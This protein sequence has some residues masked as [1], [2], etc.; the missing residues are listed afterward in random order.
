MMK[1]MLV[2]ALCLLL[3]C[4]MF[5]GCTKKETTGLQRIKDKGTLILATESTYP[6]FQYLIIEDGKTINAGLDV[7]I[8]RNFAESIGVELV[9]H[10]MAF[11]SIIPAVQAGTV[12][13]GGSFTPTPE[14]AEVVDFSD[15]YYYSN[16]NVIVRV[17]EGEQFT[18]EESLQGKRIGAQKGTVQEQILA[19]MEGV[20]VLALPK[21]TSLIQELINGNIDGIMADFSVADTYVAAYPENVE[22]A[23][24][25]IPDE[26][27]GVA[28][29]QAKGQEDLM[30][31]LN[32][33]IKAGI[34][35]G[36]IEA[37]YDENLNA[38][39]DQILEAME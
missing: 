22:K 32:D 28:M 14:R 36:S 17:G 30:K 26:S 25:E 15:I 38:A 31:A 10:E 16:H 8:M 21:V 6:P 1:K 23:P 35:D 18:G 13:F 39:I 9:V 37:L 19:D 29:C 4:S 7:D 5:V 20:D 27:G 2:M 11:D 3:V 12:D 24:F 33:Y 34:E